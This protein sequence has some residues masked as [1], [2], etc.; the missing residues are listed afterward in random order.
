[1]FGNWFHQKIEMVQNPFP[2]VVIDDF[3][4]IDVANELYEKFPNLESSD[5]NIYDNP[6][7]IKKSI[8]D[9]SKVDSVIN[10]YFKTINSE[11]FIKRIQEITQ[12]DNLESDPFLH[13]GGVHYHPPGGKLFMHLDYSIHP[14]TGKERRVNL[15][16][17][18]NHWNSSYSGNLELWSQ[19]LEK[20]E[21]EI[22]P[23][24]NRA[25][26]FETSD[27]SWHG[28]PEPV[29]CPLGRRSL[30]VYYVSEPRNVIKR[31][32][33]QFALRP[34]DL[35]TPYLTRLLEIRSK[36]RLTPEDLFEN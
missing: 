35:K 15:I 10:Q 4:S 13:G 27:E 5:W 19:G 3:L 36:R 1:M 31:P 24:F 2:Y 28:I 17:Y 20:L 33:A 26:I 6:I 21:C 14:L 8:I 23:I 22:E 18:L 30:A 16:L 32:K 29:T 25:V 34:T 11:V 7:E 9:L 12:I